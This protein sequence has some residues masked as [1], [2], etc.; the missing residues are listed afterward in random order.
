MAHNIISFGPVCS[1]W[2][3][4]GVAEAIFR[5]VFRQIHHTRQIMHVVG[6]TVRTARGR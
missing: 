1:Y 6:T 5:N 2:L 3:W 4:T